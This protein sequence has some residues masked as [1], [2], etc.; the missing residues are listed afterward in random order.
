MI[1]KTGE[2][3]SAATAGA[4]RGALALRGAATM[5]TAIIF[6]GGTGAGEAVGVGV[7]A[8]GTAIVVVGA[9]VGDAVG[10]VSC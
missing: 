2:T 6:G 1:G 9:V 10:W 4:C 5:G 8:G 3:T 7:G